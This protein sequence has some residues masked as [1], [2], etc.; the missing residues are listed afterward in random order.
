MTSA[1]SIENHFELLGFGTERT[2]LFSLI[3]QRPPGSEKLIVAYANLL[4][5][6][7]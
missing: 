7:P 3:Q 6:N 5:L 2:G 1:D 4:G